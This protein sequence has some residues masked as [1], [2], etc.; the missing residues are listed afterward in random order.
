MVKEITITQSKAKNHNG[1]VKLGSV[2]SASVYADSLPIP[3][4]DNNSRDGWLFTKTAGAEKFNY[5]IYG[6]G[7]HPITLSQLQ[8]YYCSKCN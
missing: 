5:Y 2:A 3:T 4:A 8:R 7:S 6:Q 1:F